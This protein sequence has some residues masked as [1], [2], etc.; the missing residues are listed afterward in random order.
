MEFNLWFNTFVL[1][2]TTIALVASVTVF[3]AF[4]V[5]KQ[6][7]ASMEAAGLETL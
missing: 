1:V 4:E 5:A 6:T 3:R 2:V 7:Y